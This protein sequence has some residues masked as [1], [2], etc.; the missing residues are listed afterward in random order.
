MKYH[1]EPITILETLRIASEGTLHRSSSPLD[2]M[3]ALIVSQH[4]GFKVTW[5]DDGHSF[6]GKRF[7]L[8]SHLTSLR[9]DVHGYKI[10]FND[11]FINSHHSNSTYGRAI[12]ASGGYLHTE[13]FRESRF[14]YFQVIIPMQKKMSTHY[15]IAF[16]VF[17]SDL[18]YRSSDGT[19]AI[20]ADDQLQICLLK[21][22]DQHFLSIDSPL[23]QTYKDFS[24]KVHSVKNA[25]G[26]LTGHLAADAGCFFAYTRKDKKKPV[27][28]FYTEWRDSIFSSYKPVYSNP[29]GYIKEHKFAKKMYE[30]GALRPLTMAE[31]GTLC[32]RLYDSKAFTA[33][34]ILM[35]E[36]SVAS[37]LFMPGG[38][39]IAMESLADLI[40]APVKEKLAPI[41]T[42]ALSK[43]IRLEC[44]KVIRRDCAE[45]PEEDLKVLLGRIDQ[46][47]QVTNKSRLRQPFEQLGI[48][49]TEA[50]LLIL[51]TRN[52]FLHGRTPDITFAG[53][54]RT[55]ERAGLDLYYASMRF[56]TLLNRLILK[57]TGYENYVLNHAKI[58]EK[59][60]KIKLKEP[61]YFKD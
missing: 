10:V 17:E 20:F 4:K 39:A 52:D 54:L 44:T 36:A 59:T 25:L 38:F 49:L 55:E 42:P 34:V 2:G 33:L 16:H 28:F 46:L 3:K 18:G 51:G 43:K 47:N 9:A 60:T 35:L 24:E 8:G 31:F 12:S 32:Q 45:L 40:I 1:L 13:G 14:Y 61:Y 15:A 30:T 21:S 27:H 22:N 7:E 11:L 41:K 6:R 19:L 56:Y 48:K 58:Q 5:Q 57:W 53:E 50:D 29:F 26:Y 23:K 37:L